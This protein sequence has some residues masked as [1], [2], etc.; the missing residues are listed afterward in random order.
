MTGFRDRRT[1]GRMEERTGVNLCVGESK[2]TKNILLRYPKYLYRE[3]QR[4]L[5]ST[6]YK[7]TRKG[8]RIV[9]YNRIQYH[10][11]RPNKV[12]QPVPLAGIAV[13]NMQE[14]KETPLS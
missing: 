14:L 12:H 7:Y 11:V 4:I 9:K 8:K 13:V 5:G 10:T 2:K 1:D 3:I 6:Y